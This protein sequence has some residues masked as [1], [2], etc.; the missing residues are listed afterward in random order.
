MQLFSQKDEG[1]SALSLGIHNYRYNQ[2]WQFENGLLKNVG[3]NKYLQASL[4][5][6]NVKDES[7]FDRNPNEIEF[8]DYTGKPEQIWVM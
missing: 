4:F 2:Y 5:V 1:S 7:N 6:L 3:I 8:A